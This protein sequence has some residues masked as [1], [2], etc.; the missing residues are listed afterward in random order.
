[1]YADSHQ[2]LASGLPRCLPPLTPSLDQAGGLQ[3]L[4]LRGHTGPV[5]KVLL[6]PSGTD[7]VTASADGTA[8]VWDLDIGDC[9]L[10]LEGH[11]GPI[12]DMAVTSGGWVSRGLGEGYLGG[13]VS[14]RL[15][16]LLPACLHP[17]AHLV[18]S[19]T[20]RLT[21]PLPFAAALLCRCSAVPPCRR[22]PGADQLNRRHRPRIRD[23]AGLLPACAS[24]S[25]RPHPRPCYGPL[26][27]LCR[28]GIC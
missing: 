16:V 27:S 2:A 10:L 8:R 14:S 23:G 22:Q 1:M 4:A 9:V 24:R 26:G 6:T 28:D 21:P 15:A 20:C 12:T 17:A 7:A 3:R 18:N 25:H 11:A 19:V 13:G 5:T